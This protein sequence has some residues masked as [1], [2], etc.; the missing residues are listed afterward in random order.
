MSIDI[1]KNQ[2]VAHIAAFRKTGEIPA[3]NCAS[4]LIEGIEV[5]GLPVYGER[6]AARIT[7]LELWLMLFDGI[8]SAKDPEFDPKDVPSSRVMVPPDTPMKPGWRVVSPEGISDPA[9]RKKFDEAVA[10]NTIKTKKYSFQKELRQLDAQLI[11]R[12]DRCIGRITLRS[13][14]FLKEMNAA[15]AMYVRNPDRAA[16]FRSL[17]T[18]AG[19]R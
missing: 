18:P 12:A 11:A 6:Q 9:D 13:P 16:H 2:V 14:H 15:I 17:V 5:H 19:H 10:A 4:A 1:T 7:K 3:L 8:D